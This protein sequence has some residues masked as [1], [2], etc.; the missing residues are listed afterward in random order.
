MQGGSDD[1][2]VTVLMSVFNEERRVRAAVEGILSQDF[3]DFEFLVIDDGST[4]RTAVVLAEF[5]DSRLRVCRQER[6]GLTAALNTGLK[7]ARGELVARQDAD[8][9]SLPRRLA[10]QVTFLDDHPD[11]ALVG[12]GVRL[13][14][15]RAQVLA[16]YEY[17]SDH[18]RL[19]GWLRRLLNPLPHTTVV[20]RKRAV[21][22]LGGYRQAFKKGQDYDLYLR[23]VERHQIASIPEPLCLLRHSMDSA[24]FGGGD[25]EQLK[26]MI[27][28]YLLALLRKERGIDLVEMA[29]W[30]EFL[31]RFSKWFDLSPYP[32]WFRSGAARREARIAWCNADYGTALGAAAKALVWDPAWVIRRMQRAG[33]A[34]NLEI[35]RRWIRALAAEAA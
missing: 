6:N 32:R 22:G 33:S 20:F 26:S 17:P 16:E 21:L 24:T 10:R 35:A 7:E 18:E 1:P 2:K 34:Y 4:D 23:L 13:I 31:A 15:D 3:T 8:D 28:A 30:K 14:D 12:A 27:L 29:G 25:S 11:V 19:V 9:I 5:Q